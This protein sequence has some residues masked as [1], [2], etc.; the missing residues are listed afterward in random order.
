MA[1]PK[2]NHPVQAKPPTSTTKPTMKETMSMAARRRV[3]QMLTMFLDTPRNLNIFTAMSRP[4]RPPTLKVVTYISPMSYKSSYSD[5]FTSNL[6]HVPSATTDSHPTMYTKQHPSSVS[7]KPVRKENRRAN[8]DRLRT[9][10]A[11][12]P[13]R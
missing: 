13:Y 9:M 3:S 1:K 12:S 6:R 10:R 2:D 5:E 11:T 4:T 7:S 8:L